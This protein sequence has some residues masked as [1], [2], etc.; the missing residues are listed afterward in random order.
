M[1]EETYICTKS[2][3]LKEQDT[4]SH[5]G[6][7]VYT[8]GKEYKARIGY[9][10][11]NQGDLRYISAF[12]F[13]DHFELVKVPAKPGWI[14]KALCFLSIHN[15]IETG[16]GQRC[17]D[18]QVYDIF[19]GMEFDGYTIAGSYERHNEPR[20]AGIM[21]M[22]IFVAC[23]SLLVVTL[24]CLNQPEQLDQQQV[25]TFKPIIDHSRI[26]DTIER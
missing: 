17:R 24:E 7:E 12:W 25:V 18:C 15:W 4:A 16:N 22:I 21:Q 14:K 19:T 20:Y 23:I 11:N 1:K 26:P 13:S 6:I 9:I 10:T 8:A 2:V 3:Y 5:K